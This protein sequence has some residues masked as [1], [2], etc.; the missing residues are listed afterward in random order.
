MMKRRTRSK[1]GPGSSVGEAR[2][3]S[4][5][6]PVDFETAREA[7]LSKPEAL[8]DLRPEAAA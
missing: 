6:P 7:M 3:A 8:A 1:P 2:P 5:A 4:S